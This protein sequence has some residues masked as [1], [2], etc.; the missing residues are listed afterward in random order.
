M[1]IDPYC[2]C[3]ALGVILDGIVEPS[4]EGDSGRGARYNSAKLYIH[5]IKTSIEMEAL[6]VYTQEYAD[7][8]MAV[9]ISED[10]YIDVFSSIEND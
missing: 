2:M 5:N 10:G 1:L 7:N 6:N 9:V 4:F 8:A 3:Y